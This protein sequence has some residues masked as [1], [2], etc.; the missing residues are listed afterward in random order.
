MLRELSK[1]K[2]LKQQLYFLHQC[3]RM[4]VFPKRLETRL[5]KSLACYF[6][7]EQEAKSSLKAY[8]FKSN[9]CRR[10][11]SWGIVGQKHGILARKDCNQGKLEVKK[12]FAKEAESLNMRR[13]I[14]RSWIRRK[15]IKGCW[16]PSWD[17]RRKWCPTTATNQ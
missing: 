2:N 16:M 7:T 1:K 15:K 5:P 13:Y 17:V 12:T 14:K 6:W 3:K 10:I 9:D 4:K 11:Q 8:M